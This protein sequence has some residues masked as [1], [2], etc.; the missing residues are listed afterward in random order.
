MRGRRE[1]RRERGGREGRGG[2]GMPGTEVLG[3][4]GSYHGQ[5]GIVLRRVASAISSHT[6]H[7][8]AIYPIVLRNTV[9]PCEVGR[10][11]AVF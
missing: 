5:V 11:A 8:T 10:N 7:W 1:G 3:R 2:R 6:H 9:A 4:S